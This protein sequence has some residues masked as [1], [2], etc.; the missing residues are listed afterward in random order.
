MKSIERIESKR[1]LVVGDAMLDVYW[2]GNVTRISPEA[3]VPVFHRISE[4]SGLGGAANVAANL[5]AAGQRTTL[6]AAVGEDAEGDILISKLCNLEIDVTLMKRIQGRATTTKTRFLAANHQQVLRVDAE[7]TSP[8]SDEDTA[9]M[10]AAF[11]A[12]ISEYDIVVLS[13]YMKGMISPNFAQHVIG[14]ARDVGVSVITDVKG[15]DAEK[16]RGAYLIKPNLSELGVLIGTN[17]VTT[18][19]IADA[20]RSLLGVC[21]AEYI[22]TT[23]GDRGMMLVNDKGGQSVI[24]TAA[25]EVYDVSGAGDT[26]IAYLAACLANGYS[27]EEA[28]SV[29]N[30]AAGVQVGRSGASPVFL[31]EVAERLRK[32]H[33]E[34]SGASKVIEVSMLPALRERTAA[35]RIVFTNGVF[36]ILHLG[37]VDYLQRA[38]ALGDI[39]VV[40][41]NADASVKRLKGEG[42]PIN[43]E[44]D[45]ALMLAALGFVDYVVPF[46][47]DTPI[48]LIKALRPDVL[49]KGADY[50]SEDVAG[51]EFVESN[52]GQLVLLPLVEGRS[53]TS[54]IEKI[55]T[56][57][58]EV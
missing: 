7:D 4:R 20:S 19:E 38:A 2:T 25:I 17:P 42:R 1:I 28:A 47:E 16:Y 37:H 23:M 3:P 30:I 33:E 12:R 10:F 6:L 53:T 39:L 21:E 9:E 35:G 44:W 31:P 15:Q 58:A 51:R 27:V 29:A 40:G 36:D 26:V 8:L 54:I 14:I 56:S 5:A 46:G 55:G 32:E 52:G 11:D 13:D 48:D 50:K 18:D 24:E 22:L 57:S 43:G 34:F 41:I 49:V 45:R